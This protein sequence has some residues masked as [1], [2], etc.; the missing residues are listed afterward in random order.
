MT[1]TPAQNP[2]SRGHRI[3]NARTFAG[4]TSLV[5]AALQGILQGHNLFIVGE[6]G[7]GKSS[8]AEQLK[9]ILCGDAIARNHFEIPD[10]TP[11]RIAEMVTLD[12]LGE[13]PEMASAFAHAI[14]SA[15]G[16]TFE[17]VDNTSKQRLN[18]KVFVMEEA[19]HVSELFPRSALNHF[20][21]CIRS[22]EPYC[23]DKGLVL[24]VDEADLVLP[25]PMVAPWIKALIESLHERGIFWLQFVF[26]GVD[27]TL[28]AVLRSHPS[29]PRMFQT[30]KLPP[31]EAFELQDVCGYALKQQQQVSFNN[32]VIERIADLAGGF[33]D[34]VHR[35]GE[36]L[37]QLAI[38]I[39]S[40]EFKEAERRQ[41]T[42]E[43]VAMP[44]ASIRCYMEMLNQVVRTQAVDFQGNDYAREIGA[45]DDEELENAV[46]E[47]ANIDNLEFGL[48]QVCAACELNT[49]SARLVLKKLCDCQILKR[50]GIQQYRFRHPLFRFHLR[51]VRELDRF[52]AMMLE[53]QRSKEEPKSVSAIPKPTKAELEQRRAAMAEFLM[54]ES[55]RLKKERNPG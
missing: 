29:L 11:V 6:R 38:S 10:E 15:V 1:F 7:V 16:A 35:I 27:E 25:K 50:I 42:G 33:P 45:L 55:M 40:A 46:M 19:R 53:S 30:F 8:L 9:N 36:G 49:R 28:D 13:I 48:S 51:A 47:L 22:V 20:L 43:S 17:R 4:R 41:G 26:V 39:L 54:H 34:I 3:M 23:R 32:D 18:L 21:E 5:S 37:F 44:A 24:F 2:F 52:A 14:G 12:G 31:M